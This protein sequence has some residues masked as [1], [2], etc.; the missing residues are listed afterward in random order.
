MK[1]A[2]IVTLEKRRRLPQCQTVELED[3][4]VIVAVTAR[5]EDNPAG[6]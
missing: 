5:A 6:S 3:T 4:L 1:N 2:C